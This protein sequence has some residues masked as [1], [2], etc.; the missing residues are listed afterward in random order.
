LA[1]GNPDLEFGW[2]RPDSSKIIS[3]RKSTVGRVAAAG[4]VAEEAQK[5]RQSHALSL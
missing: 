3:E 1:I 4:C 2:K 5:H